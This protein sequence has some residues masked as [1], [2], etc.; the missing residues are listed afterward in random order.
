MLVETVYVLTVVFDPNTVKLLVI[1]VPEM[2]A[3][4]ALIALTVILGVP[5]SP[6]ALEAIVEALAIPDKLPIKIGAVILLLI[7]AIPI[8]FKLYPPDNVVPIPI[9]S[10]TIAEPYISNFCRVA[11]VPIPIFPL[12]MILFTGATVPI[13]VE[14]IAIEPET[15]RALTLAVVPIPTVPLII[16]FPP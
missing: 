3:E 10:V 9:L 8:T 4:E 13:K 16:A 14:P 6:K 2:V 7:F 15:P 1:S 12:T 5:A 11:V